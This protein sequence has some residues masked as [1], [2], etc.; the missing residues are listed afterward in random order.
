[1]NERDYFC[2]DVQATLFFRKTLRSI[3][4][5]CMVRHLA[6]AQHLT[7]ASVSVFFVVLVP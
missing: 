1:M 6:N 2:M 7:E 4:L 3:P 5:T